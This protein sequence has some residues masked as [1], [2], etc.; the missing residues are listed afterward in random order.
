MPPGSSHSAASAASTLA[1][2]QGALHATILPGGQDG[3]RD[4]DKEELEGEAIGM[5]GEEKVVVELTHEERM[6]A[7]FR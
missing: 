7:R 2:E 5:G 3:I 6:Y 1:P 4:Q